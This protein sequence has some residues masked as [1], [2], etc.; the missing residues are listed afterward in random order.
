M[1]ISSFHSTTELFQSDMQ[2]AC[3]CPFSAPTGHGGP[4]DTM[5]GLMA[6]CKAG[7]G[8]S[9]TAHAVVS[10]AVDSYFDAVF[11]AAYIAALRIP[12]GRPPSS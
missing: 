1:R 10:A 12:F 8:I 2:Q 11:W 5:L 7:L 6:C 9:R 3:T 4:V